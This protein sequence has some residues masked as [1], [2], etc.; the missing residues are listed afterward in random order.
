MTVTKVYNQKIEGDFLCREAETKT[1]SIKSSFNKQECKY[2]IS[3]QMMIG[4]EIR[5]KEG[6]KKEKDEERGRERS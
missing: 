3:C 5:G 1:G 4:S 6:E 2:M